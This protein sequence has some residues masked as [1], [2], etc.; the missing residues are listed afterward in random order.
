[1]LAFPLVNA[2][3]SDG[4]FCLRL[5]EKFVKQIIVSW[6]EDNGHQI[7]LIIPKQHTNM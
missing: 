7:R 2:Y 6:L 5:P 4:T 1:M 3:H